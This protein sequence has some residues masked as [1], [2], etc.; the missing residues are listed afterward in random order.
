MKKQCLTTHTRTFSDLAPAKFR[1]Q[2]DNGPEQIC[3]YNR[4]RKDTSFNSS[5][6]IRKETSSASEIM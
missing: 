4:N 1:T 3:S 5:L 2:V 6:A